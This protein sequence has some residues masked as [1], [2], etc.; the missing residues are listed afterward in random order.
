[1]RKILLVGNEMENKM[2]KLSRLALIG[3]MFGGFEAVAGSAPKHIK[4][5]AKIY[6]ILRLCP[7]RRHAWVDSNIGIIRKPLD[8]LSEALHKDFK[9]NR[10]YYGEYIE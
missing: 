9:N 3:G 2:N 10:L 5:R 4:S 7:G 1:M 8:S 6:K